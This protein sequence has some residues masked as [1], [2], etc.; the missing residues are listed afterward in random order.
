MLDETEKK[1]D[2]AISFLAS[3]EPIARELY[4]G[5]EGLET[6]FYPRHQEETAGTDGLESATLISKLL[7]P[8]FSR[9]TSPNLES[10]LC[11]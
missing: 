7:A 11:S 3:D 1:Y 2:V 8:A 5:L 10:H 4:N 9:R 6:F